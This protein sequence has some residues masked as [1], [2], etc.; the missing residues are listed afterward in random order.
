MATV[1]F[2]CI[3]C[4]GSGVL[5][6]PLYVLGLLFLGEHH[7]RLILTLVLAELALLIIVIILR[8][9][10]R[11]ERPIP[12]AAPLLSP[13]NRYSFPSHHAMRV[14]MIATLV[15]SRCPAWCPVFFAIAAAV[16]VSRICLSR[17]HV[18]DVLAGAALGIAVGTSAVFLTMD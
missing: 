4:L 17:H 1:L 13:W 12:A 18:S 14:C 6:V 15:G 16:G 3:T 2:R 8:Y 7:S 5:W 10:T 9:A 11:R